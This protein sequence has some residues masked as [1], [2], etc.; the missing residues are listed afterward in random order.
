VPDEDGDEADGFDECLCPYDLQENGVLTDD[1]LAAIFDGAARDVRLVLISDSCCSG[2]VARFASLGTTGMPV[3]GSEAFDRV[4]FLPPATFD[5][6]LRS[7]PGSHRVR[8]SGP[9][10]KR[11]R[12]LLLSGCQDA[13]YSYDASFGGRP[14]GAF[15]YFALQSLPAP[16]AEHPS[17]REWFARI[18]K[19]LPSSRHPQTPNLVGGFLQKRWTALA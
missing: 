16:G 10:G 8:R 11:S 2:T 15:T 4:R 3:I 18:R 6:S 1:E 14:N 5:Q 7:V 12:A 9:I 19:R 13:E 17:Y